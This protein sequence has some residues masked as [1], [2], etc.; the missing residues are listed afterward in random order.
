MFAH[1]LRFLI[2]LMFPHWM[3]D[4]TPD[5]NHFYRRVFTSRHKARVKRLY[6]LWLGAMSIVLI[7]PSLPL[8]IIVTLFTTFIS[9]S[10]L[11]EAS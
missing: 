4:Q 7:F 1:L 11:D 2:S 8:L 10:F 3:Q 5:Q 6:L 9:F